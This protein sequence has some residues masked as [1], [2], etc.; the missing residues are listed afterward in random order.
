MYKWLTAEAAREAARRSQCQ[1]N[2]KQIG[3]AM[4]NFHD[5]KKAFPSGGT[6]NDDYYYT[7]PAIGAK[8]GLERFGWA[9]QIL[10]YIEESNVIRKVIR[11]VPQICRL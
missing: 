7:D 11:Y 8:S 3:I 1:N 9:F 5:G 10:P 2:L 6:N 4:L